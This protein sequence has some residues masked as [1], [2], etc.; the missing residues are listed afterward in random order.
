MSLKEYALYKGDKLLAVGTRK[1]IAEQMGIKPE[2]VTFY[3]TPSG[4][5]RSKNGRV[6]IPLE[7]DDD[8]S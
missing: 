2:T 8:E 4:A 7:E 5:K 3:G 6:V 1:E